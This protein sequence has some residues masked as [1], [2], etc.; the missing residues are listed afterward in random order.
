MQNLESQNY[1][2]LVQIESRMNH[3]NQN[4]EQARNELIKKK[5]SIGKQNRNL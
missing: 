1:Q 5:Q 3:T 4:M 2:K